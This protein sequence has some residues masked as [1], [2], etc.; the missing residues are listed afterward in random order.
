MEWEGNE[1]EKYIY[2]CESLSGG[3]N[4]QGGRVS[5][6]SR[7]RGGKDE[8]KGNKRD[9][10]TERTDREGVKVGEKEERGVERARGNRVVVIKPIW[11]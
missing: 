8:M 1:G 5:K 2:R 6:N 9:R 7:W 3:E 11:R 10:E 4:N